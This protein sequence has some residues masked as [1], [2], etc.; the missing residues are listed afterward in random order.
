[1][2]SLLIWL[3][4]C[5]LIVVVKYTFEKISDNFACPNAANIANRG[6]E[7]HLRSGFPPETILYL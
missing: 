3:N 6:E 4:K 1:M 7:G 5:R 2:M